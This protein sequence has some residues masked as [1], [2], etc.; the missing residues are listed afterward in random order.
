M[1]VLDQVI[2]KYPSEVKIVFK[3]FPIKSHKY[4][5]KAAKA[6]L[7]A[8]KQGKFWEFHDAL[9]LH[10]KLLNDSKVRD[11]VA[12]LKLDKDKFAKDWKDPGIAAKVKQDLNEGV[13]AG[14]RGVPAVFINGR[15]LKQ[16][17]IG[18]FSKAIDAELKKIATAKAKSKQ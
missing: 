15:S 16:R 6:A 12:E 4:S 13:K 17:D 9:F 8:G 14:V 10:Y 1:S 3:N 5:E 11:I 7:A 18:G 2:E